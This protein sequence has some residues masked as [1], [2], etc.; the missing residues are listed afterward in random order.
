MSETKVEPSDED[1]SEVGLKNFRDGDKS[2]WT[3]TE[4]LCNSCNGNIW[5]RTTTFLN[6]NI[7]SDMHAACEVCQVSGDGASLLRKEGD[8]VFIGPPTESPP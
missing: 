3:R 6:N 4:G 2:M 5:V 1:E 8:D 7:V